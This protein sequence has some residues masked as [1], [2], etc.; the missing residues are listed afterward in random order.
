M[1][2]SYYQID[3]VNEL[4]KSL[5]AAKHHVYIA[6]TPKERIREISGTCITHVKRD[7][8]ISMTPIRI[9]EIGAY[10]FGRTIKL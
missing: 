5:Y 8:V 3:G 7:E 4:F 2:K 1:G 9:S 10:S 6:Y